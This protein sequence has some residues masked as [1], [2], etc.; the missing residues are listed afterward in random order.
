MPLFASVISTPARLAAAAVAL[1]PSERPIAFTARWKLAIAAP[2]LAMRAHGAGDS[3]LGWRGIPS[4]TQTPVCISA[5]FLSFVQS[6][7][8]LSISLSERIVHGRSDARGYRQRPPQGRT[9][10]GP[11]HRN[12]SRP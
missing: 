5:P 11:A 12:G 8:V 4:R 7:P 9:G 6:G 10:H 2:S 3:P 1:R